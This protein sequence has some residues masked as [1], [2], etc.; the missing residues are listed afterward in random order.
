MLPSSVD[1][2]E[3]SETADRIS[4]LRCMEG[5]RYPMPAVRPWRARAHLADPP[6]GIDRGSAMIAGPV[7]PREDP[8]PAA[9]PARR[10]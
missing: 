9:L 6:C 8:M 10:R 4:H 7:T 5:P 3:P 2:S 1:I